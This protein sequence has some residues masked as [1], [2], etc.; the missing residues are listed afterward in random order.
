MF[1]IERSQVICRLA[2]WRV[3]ATARVDRGFE[4]V[5]TCQVR[6][7]LAIADRADRRMVRR[8]DRRARTAGAP[9]RAIRAP[10]C[11]R[12]AAPDRACSACAVVRDQRD[13]RVNSRAS[14]ERVARLQL[15]DRLARSPCDT[16]SAR[17]I[18]C[19][20]LG[21]MRAAAAASTP[22]SRACSAGQPS[23]PRVGI[24]ARRE[25]ASLASRQARDA[26]DQRAQ[27][28]HRAADQQRHA[29]ARFDVG[30]GAR[31]IAHELPRRITRGGFDEIDEVMRHGRARR[32]VGLGAADVQ[33]AI[34]LRGVDA[35]DLD[36]KLAREPQREVA[37]ARARGPGQHRDRSTAA[38]RP[39]RNMRSSSCRLTCVQV[40][41]P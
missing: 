31:G 23:A 34:H 29:A 18:R 30:D 32:R 25:S 14:G 24:D 27:I 20:S 5:R 4:R 40:G 38:Q 11:S 1:G 8:S 19:A 9:H 36:R 15:R 6:P 13:A 41:R 17:W 7:K 37:L 2:S 35:D 22:A 39:R 10:S 16:S 33:P 21:W 28:Q 26:A 3:A 12:S